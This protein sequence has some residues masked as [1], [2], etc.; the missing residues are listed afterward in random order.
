MK[1][2]K[3]STFFIVVAFIA[4]F[5]VSAIVG[6]DYL[7]GDSRKTI[8]KGVDDIRLGIDIKGGVDVTFAPS[9]DYDADDTHSVSPITKFTAMKK[10]TES[11]SVS[12]G[13]SAKL[14]STLNQ[15]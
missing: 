9:G 5:T 15:L 11:S 2:T 8:I 4:L 12:L 3:K 7:F 13:K 6:L 10:A 14:T 1:K